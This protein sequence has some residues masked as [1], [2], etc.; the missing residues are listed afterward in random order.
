MAWVETT[1]GL[2]HA[3]HESGDAEQAAEVLDLLEETQE[4]LGTAFPQPVGDV[5]V[6]L[7]GSNLQLC[8]AQ[9]WLPVAR[10]YSA[11]AGRRYLAGWFARDEVHVLAPS[12]LRERASNVPG[13]R[14]V[15]LLAP[16]ALYVHLV[17]GANNPDLPPPFT[18]RSFRRYLRWAWLAQGASQY[19]SGQTAH[20]R[21]AIARRLHEGPP[22]DFPP[23]TRDASLLGGTV[24]DLLARE[25]GAMAAVELALQLDKAGPKQALR[26]AFRGRAI[27]HTT[28]T[29]RAHLERMASG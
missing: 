4:R 5:G 17:I 9:P 15:L 19:F 2:F 1:R 27:G 26:A 28:S 13:S 24:F 25:E 23:S 8:L 22:P 14:E 6:V 3:R 16:A 18:L 10:A 21:P 29:W 12:R 20:L 11:P 7:H